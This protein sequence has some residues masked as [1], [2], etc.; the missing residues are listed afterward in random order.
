MSLSSLAHAAIWMINDSFDSE[1]T[2][3]DNAKE[4]TP[5]RN[6]KQLLFSSSK[7]MPNTHLSHS[8]PITATLHLLVDK[9]GSKLISPPSVCSIWSIWSLQLVPVEEICLHY[10]HLLY[11]MALF[12]K[13]DEIVLSPT[14]LMAFYIIS[15][16]S[17]NRRVNRSVNRGANRGVNRAVCKM[18]SSFVFGIIQMQNFINP[19]A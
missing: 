14:D 16:F 3:L 7:V 4:N 1:A 12:L 5:R 6:A 17:V 18:S 11:I 2:C 8:T 13:T 19:F 15:F 10:Q 9:C